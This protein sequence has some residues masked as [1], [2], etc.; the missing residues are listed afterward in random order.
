MTVHYYIGQCLVFVI[1]VFEAIRFFLRMDQNRL[2][3]A[4]LELLLSHTGK[5]CIASDYNFVSPKGPN[6]SCL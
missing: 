3:S 5:L 6:E 1:F 2:I 4:G